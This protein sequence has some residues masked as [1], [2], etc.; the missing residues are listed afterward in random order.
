M[1]R[2]TPAGL[3]WLAYLL[4]C[5]AILLVGTVLLHV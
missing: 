1:Q 2:L 5:A 3:F 4:G